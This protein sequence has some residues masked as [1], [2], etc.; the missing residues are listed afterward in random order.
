ML[1]TLRRPLVPTVVFTIFKGKRH[2]FWRAFAFQRFFNWNG[3]WQVYFFVKMGM[4]ELKIPLHLEDSFSQPDTGAAKTTSCITSEL[5][6][7]S[8]GG[9]QTI[10]L[11][12]W[13]GENGHKHFLAAIILQRSTSVMVEKPTEKRRTVSRSRLDILILTQGLIDHLIVFAGSHWWWR[14]SSITFSSPLSLPINLQSV[15]GHCIVFLIA[16][17]QK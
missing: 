15:Y 10:F 12:A 1:I 14:D 17:H 16:L 11:Y 9:A 8:G 13:L 7:Y 2:T 4:R 5:F 3:K 6:T